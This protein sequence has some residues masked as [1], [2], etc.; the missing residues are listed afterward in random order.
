MARA[1]WIEDRGDRG[2]RWRARYRFYE[3]DEDGPADW[4]MVGEA[5]GTALTVPL[6]P[7]RSGL[8]NKCRPIGLYQASAEIVF[9]T[10]PT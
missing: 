6:V 9:I 5:T 4:R 3:A 7:P 2:L 1:G 10:S 8:A